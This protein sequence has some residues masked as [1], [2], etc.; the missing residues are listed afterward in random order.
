MTLISS[1][2][3]GACSL[4]PQRPGPGLE[5]EALV[6]PVTERV[7]L[8]P[9]VREA[10]EGIVVGRR[11]V[12][13]EPQH[14]AEE[15]VR[16]LGAARVIR[17]GLERTAGRHVEHAVRTEPDPRRPAPRRLEDQQILQ[18]GKR[19]ALESSARQGHGRTGRQ[20][21][22]VRQVDQSVGGEVGVEGDVHQPGDALR[23]DGRRARD[24]RPIQDPAG[25]PSQAPGPL[26]DEHRPVR[27]EG[28]APRTLE[29]ARHRHHADLA[30]LRRVEHDR[31]VRQRTG[32]HAGAAF[33]SL[34]RRRG[35]R[36]EARTSHEQ[37][38]PDES[39]TVHR[40]PPSSRTSRRR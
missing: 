22:R 40:L 3:C 24:R 29:P 9:V 27:Q 38:R 34:L 25:N 31:T 1:P 14:L 13:P 17:R 23:V 28:E 36:G 15:I 37:R 16:V 30:V 19:G 2:P 18:A 11:P 7:D 21:L 8:R 32:R 5:G 35:T 33:L 6:V 26:G 20:R 10:D 39:P 12:V 4:T